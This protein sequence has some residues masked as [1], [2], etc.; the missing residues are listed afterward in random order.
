MIEVLISHLH[1]FKKRIFSNLGADYKKLKILG[2][3]ITVTFSEF[4]RLT[5]GRGQ[6]VIKNKD[7]LED[8]Y[9]KHAKSLYNYLLRLSG[10]SFVAEDLLQETFCKATIS[11]SF[12]QEIEIQSWLYKVA[13]HAYLDEWRKRKRWQWVP[14]R[15]ALYRNSEMISPYEDPENYVITKENEDNIAK[16]Y[17]VLPEAYRTILYL[18]EEDGLSYVELASVLEMNENQVKVTLHRARKRRIE[19]AKRYLHKERNE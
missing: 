10:S 9:R 8:V 13:R 6:M 15:E 14:F 7:K 5:N 2:L 18:R 4:I 3:K 16:L 11:L 17:S 1:E 12:Y 19:L